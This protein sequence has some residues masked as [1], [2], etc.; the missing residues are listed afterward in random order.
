MEVDEPVAAVADDVGDGLGFVAHGFD[1]EVELAGGMIDELAEADGFFGGV[2][3][4]GFFAAKRLHGEGDAMLAGLTGDLAHGIGSALEAVVVIPFR[5]GVAGLGA[6]PDHDTAT[7]AGAEA[8]E[9][10]A[11]ACGL[12]AQQRIRCGDVHPRGLGEQPVQAEDVEAVRAGFGGKRDG[13][14]ESEL[15]RIFGQSEWGELDGGVAGSGDVGAHGVEGFF[16]VGLVADGV[17]HRWAECA[18]G[19]WRQDACNRAGEMC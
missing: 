17:A 9:V 2:E 3:E 4:V 7:H 5:Q 16:L 1:V 18:G 11:K 12:P 6:A 15:T 14:S 8:H 19:S 10:L 13:V